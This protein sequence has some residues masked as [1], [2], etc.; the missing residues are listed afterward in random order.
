MENLSQ[1][2]KN[3]QKQENPQEQ[4]SLQKQENPQEQNNPQERESLLQ[5][6]ENRVETAATMGI[7][8]T[9]PWVPMVSGFYMLGYQVSF[10]DF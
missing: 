9:V 2:Q 7:P 10:Y 5:E 8:D 1:E 3:L 6:R 4:N